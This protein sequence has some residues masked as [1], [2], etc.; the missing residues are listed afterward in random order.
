MGK[1]IA[2]LT[3]SLV[4]AISALVYLDIEQNRQ[5]EHFKIDHQ[6]K[7]TGKISGDLYIAPTFTFG[8]N[9]GVGIAMLGTPAKTGW[10]CNDGI[11]YWK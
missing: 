5:W 6:C 4:C 3:L 7:L 2:I 11:L 1:L 10:L 8:G 9:G